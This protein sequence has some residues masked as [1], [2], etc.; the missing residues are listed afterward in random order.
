MKIIYENCK[1]KVVTQMINEKITVIYQ[2]VGRK[3][4]LQRVIKSID[5]FEKILNG[6]IKMIPYE[7]I[8]IICREERK[9][10]KPNIYV[11]TKFLSIG[12][13][14]RGD[15]IIACK[16]FKSLTKDQ[17]IKFLNFLKNA[18]FNYNHATYRNYPK[19]VNRQKPFEIYTREMDTQ[20]NVEN[21]NNKNDEV[22]QM[23]LAIQ[24]VILKFIKDNK[25]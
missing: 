1:M 23:I 20:A 4:K 22:L 3:P 13:T 24:H 15:I 12:E 6:K 2:E 21:C 11:N 14:I 16:D 8:I 10:L 18:S 9:N 17:A 5:E 19:V 25:N 7:D